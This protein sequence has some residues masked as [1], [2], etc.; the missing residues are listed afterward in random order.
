M[1]R[2]FNAQGGHLEDKG[3]STDGNVIDVPEHQHH[4]KLN[5]FRIDLG[6]R[7][8]LTSQWVLEANLPY[9]TK[10]QKQRL[11]RL[12]R[13]TPAEWDAIVK[14]RD[15]HHRNEIYIGPHGC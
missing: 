2:W 10:A 11:K 8:H 9:E 7:Y 13:V 5:I 6:L 4:V 14:N 15:N 12:R 3:I 1:M